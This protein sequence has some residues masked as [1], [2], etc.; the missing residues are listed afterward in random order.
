MIL[1]SVLAGRTLS[2]LES[3][4]TRRL[5]LTTIINKDEIQRKTVSIEHQSLQKYTAPRL[6]AAVAPASDMQAKMDI[7]MAGRFKTGPLHFA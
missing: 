7:R 4:V 5:D 2:S 3:I 1:P 6:E